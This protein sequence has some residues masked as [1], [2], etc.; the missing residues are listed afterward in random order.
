MSACRMETTGFV[1]RG[2]P[3]VF[4]LVLALALTGCPKSGK[5]DKPAPSASSSVATTRV[6]LGARPGA[7]A[8]TP[9]AGGASAKP[10]ATGQASSYGGTYSVASG[11][12]YISETK[13]FAGVKQAKDD[14]AKHVGDGNLSLSVDVDGRVTGTIDSGPASPAVI[15]GRVSGTDLRANVR[16]K[17]PADDG[18]TGTLDGKVSGDTV[19]GKLSLAESTAAIVREGKLALKKK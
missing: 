19:E 18:L 4:A 15:D 1:V 11:K 6:D 3:L 14:P 8:G 7:E 5:G 17:D 9:T 13:E 16:R 10:A 12:M 2:A